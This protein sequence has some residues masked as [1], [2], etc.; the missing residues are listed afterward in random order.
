MYD[1]PVRLKEM[2]EE[3]RSARFF[4]ISVEALRQQRRDYGQLLTGPY[5]GCTPDFA[6]TMEAMKYI[7][8]V[9]AQVRESEAAGCSAA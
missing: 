9:L 7:S 1:D 8:G 3:E 5:A 2:A 4:G 6:R